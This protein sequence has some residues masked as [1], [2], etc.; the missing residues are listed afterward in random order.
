MDNLMVTVEKL[1]RM[2]ASSKDTGK[3][4]GDMVKA[5]KYLFAVRFQLVSGKIIILSKTTTKYIICEESLL[6]YQ[7]N[8]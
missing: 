1:W 3:T 8:N 7:I 4:D 6:L 5:K 2:V